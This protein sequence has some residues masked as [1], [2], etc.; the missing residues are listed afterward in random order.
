MF[1]THPETKRY[2]EFSDT[3]SNNANNVQ[4]LR[5]H[6]L[7]FMSVVKKLLSH[8]DNKERFDHM[9]LDLGRRHHDYHA[10]SDLIV[11]S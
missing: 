7:R 10:N 8:L 11:V 1:D 3:A 6:G 2:F 4:G 5:E 9:L